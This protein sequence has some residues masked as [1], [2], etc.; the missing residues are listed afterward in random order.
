MRPE[1]TP[2]EV[3]ILLALALLA[4]FFSDPSV[5]SALTAVSNAALG[6]Q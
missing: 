4:A 1:H 3:P 6:A 5:R 2:P